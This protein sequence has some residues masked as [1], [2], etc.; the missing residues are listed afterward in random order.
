[1]GLAISKSVFDIMGGEFGFE[2]NSKS[3]STCWFT[4]PLAHKAC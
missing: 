4:L 3:G 1:M 2:R